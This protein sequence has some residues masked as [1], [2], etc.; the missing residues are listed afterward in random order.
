MNRFGTLFV[1]LTCCLVGC[2]DTSQSP[3]TPEAETPPTVKSSDSAESPTQQSV[4]DAS[5]SRTSSDET[6]NGQPAGS[7]QPVQPAPPET[8]NKATDRSAELDDVFEAL[9][10]H[11]FKHNASAMQQNAPAYFLSIKD[12]DPSPEFL[13]R[14]AGHKPPVKNGT[15]FEIGKGLK[16]R[17]E[18]WK[19]K[20]DDEL[21][22]TGGYYEAGLS[23]SGNRFTMVRKNGKWIVEKDQMEWIS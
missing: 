7:E 10:R 19:W 9:F 21:E 12:K 23:A 5:S 3:A 15:E 20:S 1:S 16:F 18:S 4:Q 14:F 17:I 8:S 13:K 22:L 2:T 11:Q 6:S